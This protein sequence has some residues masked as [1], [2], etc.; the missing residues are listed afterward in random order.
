MLGGSTNLE[1]LKQ[2]RAERVSQKAAVLRHVEAQVL[3]AISEL[4]RRRLKLAVISNTFP[5][6]V[7]GWDV[8][9]LRPLFDAAIFSCDVKL[10]KPDARIYLIACQRLNVSPQCA[11][12][13]GD[14]IEEVAG[15]RAAGLTARRALWFASKTSAA[16]TAP[17][18]QVLWRPTEV[19][20][21][22]LAA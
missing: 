7:A 17:D 16:A 10:A 19:V 12:F 8:S 21:A 13:I 2:V 11:L 9:P 14:G 20:D 15:A 5:E 18:D 6:D 22:A 4:R 3:E 1:V